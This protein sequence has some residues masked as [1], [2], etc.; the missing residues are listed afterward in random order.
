MREGSEI[1]EATQSFRETISG[2]EV[3]DGAQTQRNGE[4]CNG[5]DI[6]FLADQEEQHHRL[7][8]F[9]C[10]VET[11]A[12]TKP[13]LLPCEQ[14][15]KHEDKFSKGIKHIALGSDRTYVALQQLLASIES[16]PVTVPR[17]QAFQYC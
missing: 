1:D 14:E 2:G 16:D 8:V 10:E 3:G 11:N 6:W 15:G 7:S 12:G 4:R 9:P 5:G 13:T 17:Y